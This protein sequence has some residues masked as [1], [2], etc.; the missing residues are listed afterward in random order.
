MALVIGLLTF[1]QGRTISRRD[2][3]TV[4]ADRLERQLADER[5]QRRLLTSYVLDLRRWGRRI[6]PN[7]DPI[8]EPP[9]ELDLTPWG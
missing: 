7:D 3:F 5:R 9:S 6:A 8:P 1:S 2:D 4:I